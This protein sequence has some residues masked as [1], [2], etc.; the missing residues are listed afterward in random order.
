ML[1]SVCYFS[2]NSRHIIQTLRDFLMVIYREKTVYSIFFLSFFLFLFFFF[3]PFYSVHGVLTA[4]MWK[5]KWKLLSCVWLSATLSTWNSPGRNTGVGSLSL[6]QGIFPTQGSNPGLLH[7]RILYQLSYEGSPQHGYW[8]GFP[9]AP[10]VHHVLSELS[11]VTHPSWFTELS[12]PF[13]HDKEVIHEGE[14]MMLL[15]CGPG[16]DSWESHGPQRDQTS[17]F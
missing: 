5:W 11:T 1:K 15:N 6:L 13:C 12:K 4:R 3:L 10:P 7:C 8:S 9:F 17:Q 2:P 14:K 16:E